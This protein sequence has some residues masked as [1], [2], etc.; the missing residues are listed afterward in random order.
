MRT[1]ASV[2]LGGVLVT[3]AVRIVTGS[4]AL[5]AR[6][7]AATVPWEPLA[8]GQLTPRFDLQDQHGRLVTVGGPSEG[9]TIVSFFRE[10]FTPW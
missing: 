7:E 1:L 6:L 2:L 3:L 10:A 8:V 5:D 4:T 9:W